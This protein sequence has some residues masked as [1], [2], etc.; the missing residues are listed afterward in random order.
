MARTARVIIPD[1]PHHITHRGNLRADVFFNDADRQFYL[2]MLREIAQRHGVQIWA[3]CLMSNHVHLIACAHEGKAM[4]AGLGLAHQRYAS[5]TNARHCW[6]GNLWANRFYS[7]A[8]DDAHLWAA[9][10]YVELN[11]V[12][13]GLVSNALAWPWSSAR[14]HAGLCADMLLHPDRPFPSSED[15]WAEFLAV[16]LSSE[17]LS[18]I[19]TNTQTGRPTGSSEFIAGLERQTGRLLRPAKRGR[20]PQVVPSPE[21]VSKQE[22]LFG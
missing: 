5:A 18:L 4:S 11:P 13:A 16:D 10:R 22:D 7:T 9:V 3:Y 1:C 21:S 6:T 2:S 14:C 19:R 20:K 17:E 15:N 8:L 12:R